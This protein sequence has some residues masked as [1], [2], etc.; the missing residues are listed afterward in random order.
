[1][2]NLPKQFSVNN[3]NIKPQDQSQLNTKKDWDILTRDKINQLIIKEI[4]DI[5]ASWY[6]DSSIYDDFDTVFLNIRRSVG[7]PTVSSRRVDFKWIKPQSSPTPLS[8]LESDGN[9]LAITVILEISR[10]WWTFL[11]EKKDLKIENKEKYD[12]DV[13]VLSEFTSEVIQK[14]NLVIWRPA[15]LLTLFSYVSNYK[16]KLSCTLVDNILSNVYVKKNNNIN[17]IIQ[18]IMEESE[19]YDTWEE[20]YWRIW[21]SS[22]SKDLIKNTL[23]YMLRFSSFIQKDIKSYTKNWALSDFRNVSFIV[24]FLKTVTDE[25]FIDPKIVLEKIWKN[26]MIDGHLEAKFKKATSC[27][28]IS[29][30]NLITKYLGED[31]K[32]AVVAYFQKVRIDKEANI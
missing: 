5:K 7:L 31:W 30:F 6:T 17:E 8:R 24:S 27:D 28:S 9:S 2:R 21:F 10:M 32:K 23:I 12:K 26:I 14:L 19:N 1:M 25:V 20:Y 22:F 4:H 15:M 29:K 3:Q 16:S 11:D 13:A 18:S